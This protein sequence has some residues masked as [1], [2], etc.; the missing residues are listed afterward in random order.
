MLRLGVIAALALAVCAVA[1]G[2]QDDSAVPREVGG[3]QISPDGNS[4]LF[5]RA[6]IIWRMPFSGGAATS[7]HGRASERTCALVAGRETDRVPAQAIRR[8]RAVTDLRHAC[9]RG[10]DRPSIDSTAAT[11]PV[12]TGC[13]RHGG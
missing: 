1:L 8:D 5:M 12:R 3:A 4:V 7:D 11:C 9:R 10:D 2:N 13:R 6:G